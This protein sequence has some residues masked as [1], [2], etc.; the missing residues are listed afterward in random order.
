MMNIKETSTNIENDPRVQTVLETREEVDTVVVEVDIDIE[1]QPIHKELQNVLPKCRAH[2]PMMKT[3][4]LMTARKA[5]R[6]MTLGMILMCG[7]RDGTACLRNN[8]HNKD[9]I[10]RRDDCRMPGVYTNKMDRAMSRV[11]R[12]LIMVYTMDR[13]EMMTRRP[14][15]NLMYKRRGEGG[16][17]RYIE[18]IYIYGYTN[19]E[20]RQA[21]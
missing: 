20:G 13:L 2:V 8:Q 1:N 18:S 15:S 4:S 11:W 10:M 12:N 19:M 9:I 6:R 5:T 17:E 3:M 21:L 14:P 16:T 7:R